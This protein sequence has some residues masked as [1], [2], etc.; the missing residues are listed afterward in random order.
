[1]DTR[2]AT[3]HF[4]GI[5]RYVVNL[6]QAMAP[7]LAQPEDLILLRDPSQP[8]QWDLGAL[9][10]EQVE[11]VETS[12]S[13]FSLQQQW[14]VPRLLRRLEADL[15]HSPY[16]LM[17]YRPGVPTLVTIHDLIPMRYP[18]YF[19]PPQRLVFAVAVRLAVCT[20]QRVITVSQATARDLQDL[21]GLSESRVAVIPEAA[22]P[23][24]FP[25]PAVQVEAVRIKYRLS[26]PYL[27]YL[28]SNKPHKNVTSLVEAWAQFHDGQQVESHA[29]LVIAGVWDAR[30]PEPCQRAEQLNLTKSI[31]WL[32]AVP[33]SDLPALYSGAAAFVFPSLYEG[34]GLP[35]LEAMACGTPVACSD[36]SSLP[37]VAGDAALLFDPAE[38]ESIATALERSLNNAELRCELAKRGLRRVSQLSWGHSARET[39]RVYRELVA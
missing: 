28:G 30:Y 24:F 9:H 7:L 20:S 32:G 34:F 21:L 2:A 18:E 36:T 12:V 10:D 22:D 27:L 23:A 13:P 17:P 35:V 15:Y 26:E 25:R 29:S 38:V 3:D 33:E 1:L 37:E 5:G 4:P 14:T 8:S 11:V 6:A 39:L 16:Y 31:R 19:T